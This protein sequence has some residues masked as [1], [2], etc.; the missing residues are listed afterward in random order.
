MGIKFVKKNKLKFK[1]G[2]FIYKDGI[3]G[4]DPQVVSMLNEL[5]R[6]IQKFDYLDEQPE[7]APEPSLE[8][9][10]FK[11]A[12]HKYPTIQVFTP[13]LDEAIAEAKAIMDEIDGKESAE[14]VNEILRMYQPLIEWA[15]ADKI[16]IYKNPSKLP[17]AVDT[18]TIGNPLELEEDEI[19]DAIMYMK[20]GATR[21]QRVEL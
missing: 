14:E 2:Y 3:V 10:H 18:K 13:H 1:N 11:S 7:A 19:V 6:E 12:I 17:Q 20:T 8:G 5:E 21:D 16:V 4:I 15:S 9:F